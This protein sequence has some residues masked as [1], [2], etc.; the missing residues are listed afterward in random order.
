MDHLSQSDHLNLFIQLT[1]ILQSVQFDC[2][3]W[4]GR[5]NYFNQLREI[6][7]FYSG[8][9]SL[10]FKPGEPF[11]LDCP[12]CDVELIKLVIHFFFSVE[13]LS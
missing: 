12:G 2:L 6:V 13:V 1:K 4:F 8:D 5:L 3:G 11:Q 10:T 9:L 7:Q